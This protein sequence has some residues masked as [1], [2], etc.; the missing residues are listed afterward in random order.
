LES[1]QAMAVA[2][3]LQS[4][5]KIVNREAEHEG[6]RARRGS[7]VRPLATAFAVEGVIVPRIGHLFVHELVEVR[8]DGIHPGQ[9]NLQ[10]VVPHGSQRQHLSSVASVNQSMPEGLYWNYPRRRLQAIPAFERRTPISCWRTSTRS[11][12]PRAWRCPAVGRAARPRTDSKCPR[13]SFGSARMD[14]PWSWP[15]PSPSTPAYRS[16]SQ[17]PE[18]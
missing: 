3:S 5:G 18:R 1:Q 6:E 14:R 10:C 16:N 8:T 7:H 2:Q 4:H 13:V 17:V 9:N 15:F 12:G 11:W